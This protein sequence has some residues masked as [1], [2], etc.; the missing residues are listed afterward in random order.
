[1]IDYRFEDHF[2]RLTE[3]ANRMATAAV[4]HMA[5]MVVAEARGLTR[6][7]GGPAPPGEPPHEHTGTLDRSV[8]FGES[9]GGQMRVGPRA[10]VV[11]TRGLKLRERGHPLMRVALQAAKESFVSTL[12]GA[13]E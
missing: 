12:A 9:A 6:K 13:F 8:A 11:G 1:M 4:S 3:A 2:D 5:E 7:A 10:S